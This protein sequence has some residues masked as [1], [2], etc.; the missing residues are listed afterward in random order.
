MS[1][2][3]GIEL[4]K[5]LCEIYGP[6]GFEYKVAEFIKEQTEEL[7]EYLPDRMGNL[8]CLVKGSGEGYNS[9]APTKIM[10][11]AHMDE[12]GFIIKSIEDDGSVKFILDGGIDS[13]VLA[14]RSVVLFNEENIIKCIKGE[15]FD[16]A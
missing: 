9:E 7:C 1:K 11:S 16:I 13:K 15:K 3:S 10:I 4:V 2:Y 14:G 8:V 5:K 12:V 6:T